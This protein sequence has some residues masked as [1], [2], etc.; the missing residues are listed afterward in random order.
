MKAII[1]AAG[2]SSRLMPALMLTCPP[3][4]VPAKM[5]FLWDNHTLRGGLYHEEFKVHAG[6]GSLRHAA[7]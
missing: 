1:V 2:P 5:R 3:K 7:G 4:T 6:A